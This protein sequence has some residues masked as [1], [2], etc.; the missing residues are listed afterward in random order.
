MEE[1]KKVENK[2]KDLEK[3]EETFEKLPSN[4]FRERK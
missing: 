1:S 3:N 4:Y 2:D